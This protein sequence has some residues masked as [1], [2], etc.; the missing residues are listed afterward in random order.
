VMDGEMMVKYSSG[1]VDSYSEYGHKPWQ[2]RFKDKERDRREGDALCRFQNASHS[3]S[4]P[5]PLSHDSWKKSV[6]RIPMADDEKQADEFIEAFRKQLGHV[7]E[8]VQILLN[9]HL[10]V[11]GELDTFVEQIFL[12]PE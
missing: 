2:R 4:C 7:D 10:D 6:G 8:F 9:A 3:R 11:E 12:N 5:S 1:R